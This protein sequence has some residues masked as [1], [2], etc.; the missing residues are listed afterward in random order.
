MNL[1]FRPTFWPTVFTIPAV[2]LMLGLGVWQLERL[3]WK[4]AII[5]ERTQRTSA[6]PI[7]LPGPGRRC[8]RS[9]IRPRR[10]S[11]GPP[12]RQGDLP[13][14]P[15]PERQCR[16]SPRH[17]LPAQG[18]AHPLRRPRLDPLDRKKPPKRAA[19]QVPGLVALDAVIRL[20]R[21]AELAGAGQPARPRFLLLRRSAGHGQAHGLPQAETRFFLEAGPAANP[22]GFPS[23]ARPASTCPTTICNTPSPGSAWR[24][25]CW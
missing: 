17:A 7:P 22:G 11:R 19:G 1:H 5:A 2:L 18:R 9:R 24:A 20:R 16:L 10:A 6:A 13:R 8:R 21:H 3:Q 23:A 15:L 4:K 12:P 14:R 25:R